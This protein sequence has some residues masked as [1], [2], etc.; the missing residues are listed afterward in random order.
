VSDV[1]FLALEG[2]EKVYGDGPAP[3]AVLRGVDLVISDGEMLA[4]RGP[5]GSGKTTLLNLLAGLDTPSAGT[6][7]FRGQAIEGWSENQ[8]A[9]WRRQHVGFIFQDFRLLPRLTALENVALPLDLLGR[10]PRDAKARARALL[11]GLGL[12]ERL[13]HFPTALSGGEQ[14][15]VAIARAFAHEPAVVF[16]DEPTGNLD[17]RTSRA[18]M[19]Q[20]LAMNADHGTVLVTVTH[21]AAVAGEMGRTVE[22]REGRAA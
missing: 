10:S 7:R 14:Q 6:I 20:L 13:G 2:V 11:E 3:L 16:A 1:A 15:R 9:A 18:V 22:L 8:R 19:D 4:I 21:D 5:S 12:G 17:P